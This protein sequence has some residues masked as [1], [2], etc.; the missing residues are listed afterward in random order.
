MPEG[1][2]SP[3][4]APQLFQGA[5]VV[6]SHVQNIFNGFERVPVK[7]KILALNLI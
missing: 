5:R 2:P 4:P 3:P 6:N 7:E 1:T